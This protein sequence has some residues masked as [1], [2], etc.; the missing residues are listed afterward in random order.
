[1]DFLYP[2]YQAVSMSTRQEANVKALETTVTILNALDEM[3]AATV[4]ELADHLNM[5]PSTVHN[6]VSTLD[7]FHFVTREGET[8]RIGPRFL[9]LGGRNRDRRTVYQKAR[10]EIDKLAQETGELA[11]LMIEEHGLGLH[12]YLAEGENA[13]RFDAHTGKR[14]KLH[15]NALGKAILSQYSREA[16]ETILN[17]HGLEGKTDRTI[18]DR[19]AFFD[20]LD[21]IRERG[22]AQDNE[23]RIDGLR[24]VSSPITVD[25]TVLGSVSV[26]GP[27]SRIKGDRF[28][29]TLPEKVVR[30]TDVLAINIQYD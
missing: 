13:L 10:A 20:E 22:F 14:F 6:H 25:D 30:T 11:N 4:S 21:R 1:M 18:T 3:E 16:V 26:S 27:A 12:L 28:N 2:P 29:E 8:Y 23:E 24:C 19:D 7:L 5:P 9:E 17:E 15:N